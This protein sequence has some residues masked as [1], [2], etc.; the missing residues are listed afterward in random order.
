M[1]SNAIALSFFI[2]I[3]ERFFI[4]CKLF[5]AGAQNTVCTFETKQTL[6]C[7]FRADVFRGLVAMTGISLIEFGGDIIGLESRKLDICCCIETASARNLHHNYIGMLHRPGI[8][9]YSKQKLKVGSFQT[10]D[11]YRKLFNPL[12]RLVYF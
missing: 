1:L 9:K 4:T 12:P 11:L 2:C 6:S 7:Q 5:C 8:L 3:Y 10:C